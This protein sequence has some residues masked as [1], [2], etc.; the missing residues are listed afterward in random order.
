MKFYVFEGTTHEFNEAAPMMGLQPQQKQVLPASGAAIAKSAV[1]DDGDLTVDQIKLVLTRRPVAENIKAMLKLLY[2]AGD[3]RVKS[4]DLMEA[5]KME[6]ASFRGM[7]GA[8]G[9]RLAT[10]FPGLPKDVRLFDEFWDYDLR[11]KTWSLSANV[12]KTIEELRYV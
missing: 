5:L 10:T 12:R 6:P 3:K 1:S 4:D 8:F 11:Q 9:H 7:L 2:K